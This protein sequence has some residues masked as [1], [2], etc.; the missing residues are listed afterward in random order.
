MKVNLN[1][2][3][4]TAT[5]KVKNDSS[6]RCTSPHAEGYKRI[7]TQVQD[8]IHVLSPSGTV[9]LALDAAYNPLGLVHLGQYVG[10]DVSQLLHADDVGIMSEAVRQGGMGLEFQVYVRYRTVE[11]KGSRRH[12]REK[13]GNENWPKAKKTQNIYIRRHV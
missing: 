7:L 5:N 3:R 4:Y 1:Q 11:G 10:K 8:F 2:H 9:I 6:R 12:K 13:R